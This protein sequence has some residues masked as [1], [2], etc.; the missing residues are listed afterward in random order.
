M[1][2]YVCAIIKAPK[3]LFLEKSSTFVGLEP[4]TSLFHAEYIYVYK[5]MHRYIHLGFCDIV[6]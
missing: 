3:R 5:Y 6:V 4:T 2:V 1:G